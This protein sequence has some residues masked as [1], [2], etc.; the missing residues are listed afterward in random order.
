MIRLSLSS[1]KLHLF[2]RLTYN[3]TIFHTRR[4]K[5]LSQHILIASFTQSSVSHQIG[6]YFKKL[7]PFED[8]KVEEKQL[9]EENDLDNSEHV[10]IDKLKPIL[11]DDDVM[12]FALKMNLKFL[13]I[14]IYIF[15]RSQ[16]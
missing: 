1:T 14:D 8:K 6:D 3:K 15:Y 12:R 9:N 13:Y 16:S 4:I 10:I 2:T 11:K 5:K 7:N